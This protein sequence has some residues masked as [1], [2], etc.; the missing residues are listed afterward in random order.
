MRGAEQI[1]TNRE[2]SAIPL[3]R[4]F[5][6]SDDST[7]SEVDFQGWDRLLDDA[8]R[9]KSDYRT[10]G[11]PQPLWY[12]LSRDDV[13]NGLRDTGLFSSKGFHHPDYES[14]YMLI[15][16]EYDPPE[17]T[18]YRTR[19]NPYFSPAVVEQKEPEIRR[20]CR[21]LVGQ[22]ADAGE[23]CDVLDQFALRFPTTVFLT[24][25]GLPPGDLDQFIGWLHASQHTSHADDPDGTIRDSADRAIHDFLWSIAEERRRKPKDDIISKM[26]TCRIDDRPFDKREL[27][28]ILYLLFLAGLDT[29]ASML[30]WSF[31]HLA[32]H[33]EDR[34][35]IAGDP[36]VI[37][38]AVE[39]LLRF[40][41]ILTMSRKVTRDT[42]EYGCPMREGD[43]VILPLAT[44]NRDPAAFPDAREFRI[45]RFPNRHL[46]FGA[47]PH[48]CLGSH[49]AR[50]ELRIALE[51]WH[52]RIPE[53]RLDMDALSKLKVGMFVIAPEQVKVTWR[54]GSRE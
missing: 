37:P 34:R 49:L 45:D 15:P 26:L 3:R 4:N 44:A 7:L 19:L 51:E 29:V 36:T 27:L 47:G 12:L 25:L 24:L 52:R 8:P 54:P 30:G 48:R 17:H 14:E 33:P 28:G 11:S 13:Y 41:P 42:G 46:A 32:T 6:H 2:A 9:F 35:R 21:E 16:S 39:E 31:T 40:Y 5:L 53:Y 43:R 1:S 38:S 10:S 50:L 22:I 23:S 20:R 18:T